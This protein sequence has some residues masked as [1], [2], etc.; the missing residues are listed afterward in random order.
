LLLATGGKPF[1]PKMEG[2]EKDGVFTFTTSPMPSGL[3]AKIDSIHAK[4]AVVIG[5]G[6]IGISVT[7]ALVETWLKSHDGGVARKN[8]Q[9]TLR[10]ERL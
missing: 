8:P 5:A 9:L 7:E 2:S 6:L 10:C 1:V 4:A 3:A